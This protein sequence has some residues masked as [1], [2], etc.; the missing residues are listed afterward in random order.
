[1]RVIGD[2]PQWYNF[3]TTPPRDPSGTTL[4]GWQ[5][6]LANI[7]IQNDIIQDF[8]YGGIGLVTINNLS[9]GNVIQNNKISNIVYVAVPT[10]TPCWDGIAIYLRSGVY[11]NVTGN[12]ISNVQTGIAFSAFYTNSALSSP[13]YAITNNT[14]YCYREGIFTDMLDAT[15]FT[16]QN[17]SITGVTH[18]TYGLIANGIS[19][20]SNTCKNLPPISGNTVQNCENGIFL[21]NSESNEVFQN[22][23]LLNNVYGVHVSNWADWW[24]E[25]AGSGA[26]S[27]AILNNDTIQ[28]ST[29]AGIFMEDPEVCQGFTNTL[30]VEGNTTITGGPVGTF[31]RRLAEYPDLFRKLPR[32]VQRTKHGLLYPGNERQ[33]LYQHPDYPHMA[34]QH[35]QRYVLYENDVYAYTKS[36]STWNETEWAWDIGGV[37]QFVSPSEIICTIPLVGGGS[38]VQTFTIGANGDLYLSTNGGAAVDTGCTPV[39]LPDYTFPGDVMAQ[40]VDINGS[41]GSQMTPATLAATENMIVNDLGRV[42]LTYPVAQVV[43]ATVQAGVNTVTVPITLDA[44]DNEKSVSFSLSYD[45]TV[46]SN[47]SVALGSFIAQYGPTLTKNTTQTASGKL[48]IT[49]TMPTTGSQTT[50]LPGSVTQLVLVTFTVA[51]ESAFTSTTISFG[52]TPVA[53]QITGSLPV[54]WQQGTV[55]VSYGYEA[56]VTPTPTG[57]NNGTVNETDWVQVGR[58]V[59]GLDTLPNASEFQKADCAPASTL[60]DG[61]LSIADW[62]QAGRYAVG[63]DT[64]VHAGGPYQAVGTGS[65][66]SMAAPAALTKTVTARKLSLGQSTLAVGEKGTVTISLNALGDENALGFGVKFDADVLQFVSAKLLNGNNSAILIVN[67]R[68]AADGTVGL[69]LALS[70]GATF[71]KG[72]QG[73]VQLTF[74][75]LARAP[76]GTPLSFCDQPIT[77]EIAT[78]KADS[79]PRVMPAAWWTCSP[80]PARGDNPTVKNPVLT[81][82]V[83]ARV[84]TTIPAAS[85]SCSCSYHGVAGS[86]CCRERERLQ[87]P[88]RL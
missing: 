59:A 3:P 63:L 45:P 14:I 29:G 35:D 34:K 30:T 32:V 50:F 76:H 33:S 61:V 65:T 58:Y 47:P 80:A 36:G 25:D 49:V 70:A 21:W 66:S 85:Y 72:P 19:F 55:T 39:A 75:G 87:S 83:P 18:P 69:A 84:D 28:G 54:T 82:A 4:S 5:T 31:D 86:K 56:D 40:S 79:S 48:G 74:L 57:K 88:D 62:V 23:Q 22:N 15:P 41:T 2:L 27:T 52:D 44:L 42:W 37:T 26:Y 43:N 78:V 51:S 67:S 73:V 60:G 16:V 6:N 81:L 68:K 9:D 24:D 11:A 38:T 10:D 7:T 46:L 1:M 12:Y 71:S 8:E 17:N 13:N 64:V 77:R 53:R 20:I